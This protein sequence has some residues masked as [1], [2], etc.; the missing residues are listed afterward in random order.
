MALSVAVPLACAACNT[1]PAPDDGAFLPPCDAP[2]TV[3]P[4]S[5]VSFGGN[6]AADDTGI[7][8]S[9][10][11]PGNGNHFAPILH[12]PFDGGP[13]QTLGTVEVSIFGFGAALDDAFYWSGQ[14][15]DGADVVLSM[16]KEGG[17]IT[18]LAE[19]GTSCAPY[20]GV[21][22]DADHVYAATI[23]CKDGD[24]TLVQVPRKGGTAKPIW[25]KS[26]VHWVAS[27]AGHVYFVVSETGGV[28]LLRVEATGAPT[29]LA[30]VDGAF[31]SGTELAFD[32]V[33]AYVFDTSS[34]FAVPLDGSPPKAIATGIADATAIVADASGVYLA[35]AEGTGGRIVRVKDGEAPVVLATLEK[36]NVFQLVLDATT[37]YWT[38][39]G[40]VG[41]V[42][43]C[44]R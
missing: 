10:V 6:L 33:N 5:D 20:A 22:L 16:P 3:V 7:Y 35:T 29:S 26:G 30:H 34:V 37:L 17:A 4:G 12:A 42:G 21:A 19:M 8:F 41:H 13:L 43:K 11:Y 27:H 44:S 25:T 39:L 28:A 40:H 14:T 18:T 36:G 31:T 32:D 2:A 23:G 24:P 38:G 9:G 1:D 15:I